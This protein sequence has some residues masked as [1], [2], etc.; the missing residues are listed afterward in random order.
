MAKIADL[1]GRDVIRYADDIS[2]LT[3]TYGKTE[4]VDYLLSSLFKG[5]G[6][7]MP[8]VVVNNGEAYVPRAYRSWVTSVDNSGHRLSGR[9]RKDPEHE[10][11]NPSN[12][13]AAAIRLGLD[14]LVRTRWCL[15]CDDDVLF[16]GEIAE[17]L[18][19]PAAWSCVCEIGR[20]ISRRHLG[21]RALPY[22]CIIDVDRYRRDGLRYFGDDED[23]GRSNRDTGGSFLDEMNS[24][25][26]KIREVALSDFIVHIGHGTIHVGPS[27]DDLVEPYRDMWE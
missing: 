26:W 14:D 2:V 19:L 13:H 25:G 5:I 20:H 6:R 9:Y 22:M 21:L 23:A 11:K 15:L 4:F 3:V 1:S 8:A 18:A 10:L 16:R 17:L 12:N 27:V 24:H 7:P